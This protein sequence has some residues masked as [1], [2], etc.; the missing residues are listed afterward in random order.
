MFGR[1]HQWIC[2][3][4]NF[5]VKF[6]FPDLISFFVINLL[7][8]SI[9]S[10]VNLGILCIA[11]NLSNSSRLS[12]LLMH[13]CLERS[14]I[15]FFIAVKLIFVLLLFLILVICAF[16]L[17]I[18]VLFLFF[19]ANLAKICQFLFAI[20]V[21][22][23]HLMQTE[24]VYFLSYVLRLTDTCV[25]QGK[26]QSSPTSAHSLWSIWSFS[27]VLWLFTPVEFDIYLPR[28]PLLTL[29]ILLNTAKY[30]IIFQGFWTQISLF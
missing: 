20:Y 8:F 13:H 15:R 14:L 22:S 3:L 21:N 29:L 2:L 19:I 4:L 7:I 10:W 5:V 23:E 9:S 26:A 11:R 6:L 27:N 18:C 1:I 30:T 24:C 25:K 16:F 17:V 28:M 12:N